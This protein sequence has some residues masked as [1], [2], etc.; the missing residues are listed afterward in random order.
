[1]LNPSLT[2]TNPS[3]TGKSRASVLR[4]RAK[5]LSKKTKLPLAMPPNGTLMARARPPI[6]GPQGCPMQGLW[7]VAPRFEFQIPKFKFKNPKTPNASTKLVL[8]LNFVRG[9]AGGPARAGPS[10]SNPTTPVGVPC[11]KWL[12]GLA[13]WGQRHVARS[14]LRCP[15]CTKT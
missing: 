3:K 9:C 6:Q 1:M 4:L 14:N 10:S 7:V 13:V 8:D 15:S 11:T 2:C 12:K 5:T